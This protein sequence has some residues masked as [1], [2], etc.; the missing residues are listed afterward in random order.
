M[1]MKQIQKPMETMQV[2]LDIE[3]WILFFWVQIKNVFVDLWKRD[4]YPYLWGPLPNVEALM[5]H[6]KRE[7]KWEGGGGADADFVSSTIIGKI[8]ASRK[9]KGKFKSF[10]LYESF[11]GNHEVFSSLEKTIMGHVY[12]RRQITPQAGS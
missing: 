2:K 8:H 4:F 11:R 6:V 3:L 12:F 9:W 10:F 1:K 5:S 7:G